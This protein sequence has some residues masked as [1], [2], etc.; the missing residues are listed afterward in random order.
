[1]TLLNIYTWDYKNQDECI[2]NLKE[3]ILYYGHSMLAISEKMGR[4]KNYIGHRLCKHSV[5]TIEFM[6]EL[7]L[8]INLLNE[9]KKVSDMESHRFKRD[10]RRNISKAMVKYEH[11]LGKEIIKAGYTYTEVSVAL[12]YAPTSIAAAL[13]KDSRGIKAVPPKMVKKINEFLNKQ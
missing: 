6:Q 1:M 3:L 13:N 8:A 4:S 12:G 10:S 5:I 7:I 2:N 11:P 9:S